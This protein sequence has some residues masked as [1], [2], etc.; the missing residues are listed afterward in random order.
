MWS[1]VPTT[2]MFSLRLMCEVVS[3]DPMTA[4]SLLPATE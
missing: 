2:Q 3:D 1:D 4:A